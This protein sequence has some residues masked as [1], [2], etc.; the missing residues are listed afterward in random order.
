MTYPDF[1][2]RTIRILSDIGSIGLT[3]ISDRLPTSRWS[4]PR[5]S[6]PAAS[7]S[8]PFVSL[9]H[10]SAPFPFTVR[11]ARVS[12]WLRPHRYPFHRLVPPFRTLVHFPP[13]P[14]LP[15]TPTRSFQALV[16]SLAEVQCLASLCSTSIHCF[17]PRP[18]FP[19]RSVWFIFRSIASDRVR[20]VPSFGLGSVLFCLVVVFSIVPR[21]SRR[22]TRLA[23]VSESLPRWSTPL[24][25]FRRVL[26]VW[27]TLELSVYVLYSFDPPSDP[28]SD[29]PPPSQTHNDHIPLGPPF[30]CLPS[31]HPPATG[32]R[33]L[34]RRDTGC[35]TAFS[36]V[37]NDVENGNK[38]TNP[39]G[40]FTVLN[41]G[42]V[43]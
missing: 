34:E 9:S 43:I 5:L 21:R 25:L 33:S 41:T 29:L 6:D 16:K 19:S 20:F 1:C 39:I 24:G 22:R 35:I 36:G 30:T 13:S 42:I 7:P 8:R 31:S 4:V 40:I 28:S 27:S 3:N 32:S 11:L 17:R 18:L 23:I 38:T 26:Q 15:V 12:D 14:R 2:E 10:V 37:E